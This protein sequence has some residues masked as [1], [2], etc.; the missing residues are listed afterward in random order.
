MGHLREFDLGKI[1]KKRRCLAEGHL[2]EH[3]TNSEREPRFSQGELILA[4]A[5][6]RDFLNLSKRYLP[7]HG[8]NVQG[9]A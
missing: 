3:Y 4:K 7:W 2:N 9:K 6:G 8:S 5:V 1:R